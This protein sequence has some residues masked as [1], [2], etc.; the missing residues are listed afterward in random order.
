VYDPVLTTVQC[1]P[2]VHELHCIRILILLPYS[3]ALHSKKFYHLFLIPFSLQNFPNLL[4][5][6]FVLCHVLIVL[7]FFNLF[8]VLVRL[9]PVL[10]VLFSIVLCLC[11]VSPHYMVVY[12]PLVY[13]FTYT[14]TGVKKPNY[15]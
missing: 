7:F 12:F 2:E 6:S 5:R 14:A 10:Y 4:L 8:V 3:L 13:N 11:I 1:L 15:S 9:F